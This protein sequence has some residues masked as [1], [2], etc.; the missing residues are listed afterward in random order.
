MWGQNAQQQIL[1]FIQEW[2]LLIKNGVHNWNQNLGLRAELQ[3]M[4]K[5]FADICR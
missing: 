3:K 4:A 2:L 1:L 5:E